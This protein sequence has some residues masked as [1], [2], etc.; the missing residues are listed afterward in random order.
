MDL[1][2]LPDEVIL[3][4]FSYLN[5]QDLGNWTKV[6]KRFRNICWDKALP[7]GEMKNIFIKI[8]AVEDSI[9]DTELAIR[10][11]KNHVLAWRA[12]LATSRPQQQQGQ[13]G[14]AG[15]LRLAEQFKDLVAN[16]EVE[17]R[18]LEN[19]VLAW[20]ASVAP[21]GPQQQPRLAGQPGPAEQ[22]EDLLANTEV[23]IRKLKNDVLLW[24]ASGQPAE[25]LED[26]L[27]NTEVEIAK[28]ASRWYL[29][30]LTIGSL[31]KPTQ[32]HLMQL[33]AALKNPNIHQQQQDVTNILRANPKL[34]AA[35][36]KVRN[37]QRQQQGGTSAQ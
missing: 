14:S 18:I 36:L 3:K 10:T 17:I 11:L 35:F 12:S 29:Q 20:Q 25:Q 30:K 21:S 26:L 1:T 23:E 32:S 15:N 4:L 33:I 19:Y 16:T 24:R 8:K 9:R 7:Y 2:N 22:L 37:E 27:A 5:I 34:M 28:V 6:S 13:P 31:H